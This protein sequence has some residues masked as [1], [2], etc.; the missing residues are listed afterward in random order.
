MPFVLLY[1]YPDLH[2]TYL[3]MSYDTPPNCSYDSSIHHFCVPRRLSS[4]VPRD[5][6]QSCSI[7]LTALLENHT[8][9]LYTE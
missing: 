1:V 9:F 7:I 8:V 4:K 5:Q 6:A 3:T 2:P